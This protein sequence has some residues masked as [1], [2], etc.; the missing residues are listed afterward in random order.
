MK[1]ILALMLTLLLAL[2]ACG[3]GDNS[4]SAENTPVGERTEA[5]EPAGDEETTPNEEDPGEQEAEPE[6][7][8]ESETSGGQVYEVYT[9]LPSEFYNE[10]LQEYAE[11]ESTYMN[12]PE[13]GLYDLE[14]DGAYLADS[15]EGQHGLF[16]TPYTVKNGET[17]EQYTYLM[18]FDIDGNTFTVNQSASNERS[19]LEPYEIL[20]G[21]RNVVNLS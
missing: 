13:T 1:K 19:P 4:E 6:E 8:S 7:E 16:M 9:D 14:F 11:T 18:V 15:D 20:E 3:T 17:F 5:D 10:M 21:Y 12:D 2:T